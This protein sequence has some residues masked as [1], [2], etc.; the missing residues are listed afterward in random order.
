ML[1]EGVAQQLGAIL[2]RAH[3]RSKETFARKAFERIQ[4]D[5]KGF[6]KRVLEISHAYADQVEEDYRSFQNTK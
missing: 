1:D 5:K 2:A 6:R 3:C 4:E